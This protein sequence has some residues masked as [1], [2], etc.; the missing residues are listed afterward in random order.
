MPT[1][2]RLTRLSPNV[3]HS[4][5]CSDVYWTFWTRG[6]SLVLFQRHSASPEHCSRAWISWALRA[7]GKSSQPQLHSLQN[8]LF[9]TVC[10]ENSQRPL[11]PAETNHHFLTRNKVTKL[12][13]RCQQNK[14]PAVP[15]INWVKFCS[16]KYHISSPYNS[17]GCFRFGHD[18]CF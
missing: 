14:E 9:P 11:A 13:T 17:D 18:W 15:I 10:T 8:C 2:G 7:T 16:S 1:S 4:N 12:S 3:N 5:L 6:F